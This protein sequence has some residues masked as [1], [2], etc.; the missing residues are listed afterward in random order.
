MSFRFRHEFRPARRSGVPAPRPIIFEREPL[1]TPSACPFA[2]LL[3]EYLPS[4]SAT[5]VAC[6]VWT[7]SANAQETRCVHGRLLLTG[8]LI[9][10]GNRQQQILSFDALA[11]RHPIPCDA[12]G[13]GRGEVRLHFH[14]IEGH[15]VAASF[16]H[17][18]DVHRNTGDNAGGGRRQLA[19]IRGIGLGKI[20]ALRSAA[21][22]RGC[23]PRVTGHSI[24][25]IACACRPGCGSP[26]VKKRII[27]DLPGSISTLISSSGR[28]P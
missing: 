26:A 25:K 3:L 5:R 4:V 13:D 17:L 8:G 24:Q 20:R 27:R 2:S 14:R 6:E 23:A 15:Q 12:A 18:L 10:R 16:N 19:C 28:K 11:R 9:D 1:I 22:N 7:S 21:R